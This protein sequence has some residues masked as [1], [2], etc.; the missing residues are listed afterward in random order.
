MNKRIKKRADNFKLLIDSEETITFTELIQHNPDLDA[1]HLSAIF[2]L[3]KNESYH[4]GIGGGWS[5]IK[6]V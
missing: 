6:R 2:K 5:E 4:V 3:K 1:K